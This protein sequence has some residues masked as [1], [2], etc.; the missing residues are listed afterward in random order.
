MACTGPAWFST[1]ACYSTK[2]AEEWN[3]GTC[4][5]Q[6]AYDNSGSDVYLMKRKL[7][8]VYILKEENGR[9]EMLF[10]MMSLDTPPQTTHG[11]RQ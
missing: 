1:S 4:A 3:V 11:K 8:F 6:T 7:R 10:Q 2:N 5:E 9:A